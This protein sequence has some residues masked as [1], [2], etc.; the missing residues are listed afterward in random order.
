[1]LHVACEA[2]Q[3]SPFAINITASIVKYLI[4]IRILDFTSP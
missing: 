3:L 1:M 2:P 4:I